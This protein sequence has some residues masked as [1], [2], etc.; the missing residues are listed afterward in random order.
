MLNQLINVGWTILV[1]TPVVIYS[2]SMRSLKI[3]YIFSVISAL[4]G[5]LPKKIFD[6]FKFSADPQFHERFGVRKIR[7]FV[8]D[9][10]LISRSIRKDLPHHR[11][12]KGK[13]MF[14]KYLK[15]VEM[16][17]H[18]HIICL[19]FFL[20]LTIYAVSN[21]GFGIGIIVTAGNLLYNICPILL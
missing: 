18:Y 14:R 10:D 4:C 5:F 13:E 6:S 9:G 17:E 3:I 11:T 1:F 20:L 16:Y 12:I 2:D 15:T 21:H 19:I 7:N 8:Q